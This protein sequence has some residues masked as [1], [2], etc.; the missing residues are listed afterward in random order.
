MVRAPAK[1][2]QLRRI[3]DPRKADAPERAARRFG[4]SQRLGRGI[5]IGLFLG[6]MTAGSPVA[7]AGEAPAVS[8]E[9]VVAHL[10]EI[11]AE[12]VRIAPDS[13][14]QFRTAELAISLGGISQGV[15]NFYNEDRNRFLAVELIVANVTGVPQT[16][17]VKSIRLR[18]GGRT[19]AWQD[20]PK[21]IEGLSFQAGNEHKAIR[22]VQPPDALAIPAGATASTWLLF[23][24]LEIG[25]FI[26]DLTLEI[27]AESQG[28]LLD[29]G[30]YERARLEQRVRR[31]GPRDCLAIVEIHGELNTIN[32][33]ALAST[34][35]ELSTGGVRR[36][37]VA[38]DAEAVPPT[39]FLGDWLR[40]AQHPNPYQQ[41][42]KQM[43]VFPV[44]LIELHYV[45]GSTERSESSAQ[46]H[47]SLATA[48]VAALQTAFASMP[49]GE[50]IQS[51]KSTD[52][53]VRS[54]AL[55][56]GAHRLSAD[57]YPI[58]LRSLDA[59][60]SE[61]RRAAILALGEFAA[62]SVLA[63]LSALAL[64][65]PPDQALPA[66]RAMAAS[67]FP[68]AQAELVKLIRERKL[69]ITVE[70]V[71]TLSEHPH[72][73]WQPLFLEFA[74]ATDSKVRQAALQALSRL[75]H[76]ELVSILADGLKSE[77]ARL[78]EEAFQRLTHLDVRAADE[79]ASAY[80]LERL[81]LEPP[82]A[83]IREYLERVR[84]Q[85]AVPLLLRYLDQ[86]EAVRRSV[87]ELLTIIGDHTVAAEFVKRYPKFSASEQVLVLQTLQTLDSPLG[88]PLAIAALRSDDVTLVQR[89]VGYLQERGT[90]DVV[91][92]MCEVLDGL[93]G[94]SNTS[95]MAF[96]SNGLGIIGTPS[97]REA[98]LKLRSSTDENARRAAQSGLQALWSQSPA[99]EMVATAAV[100]LEG[101]ETLLLRAE[102]GRTIRIPD[103]RPIEPERARELARQRQ[104]D[105]KRQL[106]YAS[107]IDADYPD[108]PLQQGILRRIEGDA[109][110]AITLFRRALELNAELLEAHVELGD[111]L[112]KA[113]RFAEAIP[114]LK[115]AFEKDSGEYRHQRLT[116]WALSLVR[117]GQM[118]EALDLIKQHAD[119]F[120]NSPVFE[121][122]VA[123]LYGRSVEHLRNDPDVAP[124]DPRYA[125][126]SE[127]AVRML[128]AAFE[129]GV[130]R[131]TNDDMYSY[132]R[133]DPDLVP[134]HNVS[135][136]RKFAELDLPDDQR[137]KSPTP[138]APPA[139]DQAPAP[140]R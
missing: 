134:L 36:V 65:G 116:S 83:S 74:T 125:V 71:M 39:Q 15:T 51:I 103:G 5:F 114:P 102:Q 129:H 124:D 76:D 87:I 32:G 130:D 40:Q 46:V 43:P 89:A 55:Q 9:A 24:G 7:Q 66:I 26:P 112:Y 99:R 13:P 120:P 79:L 93:V 132:M 107:R 82:S 136:F 86:P 4:L 25:T 127:E 96:L 60:E 118:E 19:L 16:L 56:A 104:L 6:L 68:E 140:P 62:P 80:T 10:R 119:E 137:K 75:G 22:E 14:L 133:T 63:K 106:D 128:Q 78:R 52:P 12:A 72:A 108:L 42:F 35:D 97:A 1:V 21:E 70:L 11:E 34:L 49:A 105:A 123:C 122:N 45:L 109:D 57:Q 88:K 37:V 111:T 30:L 90:E 85:R 47:T 67:R 101:V 41:Q 95:A 44:T 17:D 38:F 58:V 3:G 61:V 94:K 138:I 73:A 54:A 84:D 91:A 29:V 64:S 139:E 20:R 69:P 50:V 135:V 48:V 115:Y 77:D 113:D 33:G 92:A 23:T 117:T 121:Y 100:Q 81:R 98:L 59:P 2:A 31:T 126:F 110:A 18:T 131:A 8:V 28:L 53:A 27:P